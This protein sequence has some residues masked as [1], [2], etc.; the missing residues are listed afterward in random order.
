MNT[1][2]G[3]KRVDKIKS[4]LLVAEFP[5]TGSQYI[6]SQRD[7]TRSLSA[8]SLGN[9]N[10]GRANSNNISIIQS[11]KR[12]RQQLEP[13]MDIPT[14][15]L[16]NDENLDTSSTETVIANYQ[17]NNNITDNVGVRTGPGTGSNHGRYLVSKL[18]R[19]HD[20]KERYTSHQQFL[21]KCL[22]NNIIPNGLRL[23]LE[24]TIGNHDEE[25]LQNWYSKLEEYSKN[26]MK[27]VLAFC[28]K[29]NDETETNITAVNTELHATIEKEQYD[30]VQAT[31]IQN[32]SLRSN[33]LQRKKNKKF[34]ALKYKKETPRQ[35][36]NYSRGGEHSHQNNPGRGENMPREANNRREDT[37]HNTTQPQGSVFGRN[38]AAAVIG[39]NSNNE[40]PRRVNSRQNITQKNSFHATGNAP[41]HQ[42]ISLQR[43][44]SFRRDGN[45]DEQ[46]IQ[47]DINRLQSRLDE[48]RRRNT[49]AAPE[50]GN[51]I[52][53]NPHTG[54]LQ[55]N[56]NTTQR[57]GMGINQENAI[58]EAFTFVTSAMETLKQ[59][60]TKFATLLNTH[61]TPPDRS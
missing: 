31:V 17:A 61:G 56:V 30:N 41:L 46:Q 12:N 38:Y 8:T 45:N 60:E 35:H 11:F 22:D 28:A 55:K 51:N 15:T 39:H 29:T 4:I 40:A 7:A 43:K 23:D 2:N 5:F 44:R 9:N 53:D 3:S 47:S 10:N 50:R 58:K 59:F 1:A 34:Y 32:N 24:P 14:I 36:Q 49:P 42:Q 16:T 57:N 54:H 37:R 21:Q 33:E 25:F 27:D 18:D 13:D 20:K 48:V 52:P 6:M 26:F 19:L